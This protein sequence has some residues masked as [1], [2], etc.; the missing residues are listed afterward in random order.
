M[1][2]LWNTPANQHCLPGLD[3]RLAE[4]ATRDLFETE[5]GKEQLAAMFKEADKE[6]K[7]RTAPYEGNTFFL[8]PDGSWGVM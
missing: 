1:S 5:E 3:M 7:R 6:I 8:R 2:T 4:R